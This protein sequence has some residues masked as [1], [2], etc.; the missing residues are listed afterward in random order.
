MKSHPAEQSS[1]AHRVVQGDQSVAQKIG[2]SWEVIQYVLQIKTL[3][4]N[5]PSSQRQDWLKIERDNEV[6]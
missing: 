1:N 6:G 4:K 3:S 5:N 2:A